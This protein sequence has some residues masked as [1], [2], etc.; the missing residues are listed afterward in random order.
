MCK[1][2]KAIICLQRHFL[3]AAELRGD[4]KAFGRQGK[5]NC[6]D[7]AIEERSLVDNHFIG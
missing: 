2:F 5:P 3:G 7:T 6:F 1:C 4:E